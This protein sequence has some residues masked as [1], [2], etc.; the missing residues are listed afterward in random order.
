M[1][2]E[3]AAISPIPIPQVLRKAIIED[4]EFV[5]VNKMEGNQRQFIDCSP[6]ILESFGKDLAIIH[7]RRFN[8]C[9]NMGG[10]FRYPVTEFNKRLT[11]VLSEIT[12]RYDTDLQELSKYD[13]ILQGLLELPDPSDASY[14][15]VD[16]DA[17]QFLF[18]DDKIT[19]IV[20]TEAYV[21][22]PRELDLIPLECSLDLERAIAFRRGYESI[23]AF[24][25]LHEIRRPY[26][27]FFALLQVK[28]P[29]DYIQWMNTPHYFDM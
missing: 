5:V 19:A 25:I 8:E 20:D 2:K 14:V 22:G 12:H 29:M 6:S 28:G 7:S 21:I 9:G 4:V 16:F 17:R 27:Y 24:P 15:M 13:E 11:Q 18:S 1:N 3:L 26:R 23:D 10:A